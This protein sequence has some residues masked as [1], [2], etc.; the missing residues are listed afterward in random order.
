MKTE[1][2]WLKG[3]SGDP[4]GAVLSLLLCKEHLFPVER[5]LK[6]TGAE[7]AHEVE[8]RRLLVLA[9]PWTVSPWASHLASLGFSFP[10]IR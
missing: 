2:L 5:S 9:L 10:C 4:S 3:G 8:A 1:L 6:T 7:L